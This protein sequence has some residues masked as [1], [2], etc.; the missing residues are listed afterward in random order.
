[1]GDTGICGDGIPQAFNTKRPVVFVPCIGD[2][3]YAGVTISELAMV[4][5]GDTV[6]EELINHVEMMDYQLPTPRRNLFAPLGA[7]EEVKERF[8]KVSVKSIDT[9]TPLK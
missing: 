4:F 9:G 6:N 3:A 2:R 7:V 1:L 8:V 5:P